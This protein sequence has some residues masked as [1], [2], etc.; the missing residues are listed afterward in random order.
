MEN[1]LA[2]DDDV[3][4]PNRQ[5]PAMVIGGAI[6]NLLR[7]KDAYISGHPFAQQTSILEAEA[8]CSVSSKVLNGLLQRPSLV[9]AYMISQVAGE[10]PATARVRMATREDAV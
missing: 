10:T 5:L 1:K 6:G 4:H 9:V 8:T 3:C 2:V 7:I